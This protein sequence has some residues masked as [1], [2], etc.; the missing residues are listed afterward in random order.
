MTAAA[1][2]FLLLGA[3]F[4]LAF[5][6]LAAGP[7]IAD[8]VVAL[9]L[10]AMIAAGIMAASAVSYGNEALLDATMIIALIAFVGTAAFARY[11]EKGGR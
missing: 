9:D 10:M 5:V 6:R 2:A 4:V 8:R 1:I 3:A 7:T 11:V